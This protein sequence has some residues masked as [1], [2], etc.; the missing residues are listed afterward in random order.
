[1]FYPI[2]YICDE[3]LVK[4]RRGIQVKAPPN[5]VEVKVS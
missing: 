5:L 4:H 2:E 1:M 3:N